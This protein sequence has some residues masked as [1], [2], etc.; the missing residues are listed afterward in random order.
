MSVHFVQATGRYVIRFRDA[1]GRNSNVTVNEKNL[2]RYGQP[3]PDRLTERVA[4]RLEQAILARETGT[5]G[6]IRSI[7]RRQLLWLDV[8]ARYL[9]LLLDRQGQDIWEARPSNE[10]LENEKTYSH[11]QLDRMYRILTVYFPQ[12]LD[13][14]KI[15]WR[16]NGS[17]A[18]TVQ[19]RYMPVS[20]AL[21]I[22]PAKM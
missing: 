6:S 13:R 2:H 18:T 4:K 20:D 17:V 14:G 16:R 7:G 15:S 12:Y 22:L 19:P 1:G 9:P 8:V 11:N 21:R 3:I 10:R 5:D